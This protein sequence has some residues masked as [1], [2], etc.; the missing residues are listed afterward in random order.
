MP[1]DYPR[2]MFHQTKEPVIVHSRTEEDALGPG[3]S[4]KIWPAEAAPDPAAAPEPEPEPEPE[5][6]EEPEAE[7]E[8]HHAAPHRKLPKKRK[9]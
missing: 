7:P 3:W 2:M 8:H 1:A 5:T 6:E 4:R 9:S